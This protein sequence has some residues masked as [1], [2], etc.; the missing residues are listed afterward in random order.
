[1]LKMVRKN[2][3]EIHFRENGVSKI[4]RN[5]KDGLLDG[6]TVNWLKNGGIEQQYYKDGKKDSLFTKW[7]KDQKIVE[8]RNYK[9][10][11]LDG[12]SVKILDDQKK[13]RVME[14]VKLGL[15]LDNFYKRQYIF[16]SKKEWEFLRNWL[17]LTNDKVYIIKQIEENY[18]DGLL[19]GSSTKWFLNSGQVQQIYKNGLANGEYALFG[20]NGKSIE[21]GYYKNGQ[22]NGEFTLMDTSGNVLSRRVFSNDIPK[23]VLEEEVEFDDDICYYI[24]PNKEKKSLFRFFEVF[25]GRWRSKIRKKNF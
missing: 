13:N 3:I 23:F 2:G 5:Y 24:L 22:K 18:K 20:K 7:D 1:M 8:T 4:Q 17:Y 10:D 25:L 11:K 15:D 21:T 19:D 16:Q 6:L 9:D 12:V 14:K